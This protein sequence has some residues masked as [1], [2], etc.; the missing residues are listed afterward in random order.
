MAIRGRVK[1]G[2]VVLQN[3]A[4]LPEGIL[5]EVTP[6]ADKAGVVSNADSPAEPATLRVS[7][8][9]QEALLGLIGIW[10]T[11]H[12]PSDD[13]VERIIEEERMKKYG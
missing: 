7:K 5:V 8:E 1:N 9:R 4:E 12:P 2:V 13:D 3:A 11:D 10:K 6:L